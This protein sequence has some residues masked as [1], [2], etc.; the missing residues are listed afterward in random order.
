MNK[1][2]VHGLDGVTA[3]R[4]P[5]VGDEMYR[6][7]VERDGV[8]IGTIVYVGRV[9]HRAGQRVGTGYGWRPEQQTRAKLTDKA[10][11][12]RRLPRWDA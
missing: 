10:D 7:E 11:A 12:I 6:E 5:N 2:R 4:T 3:E 8:Y 1:Y 9:K